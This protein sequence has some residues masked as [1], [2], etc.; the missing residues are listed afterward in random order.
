M[1][2][3]ATFVYKLASWACLVTMYTG[4]ILKASNH[5]LLVEKMSAFVDTG[6]FLIMLA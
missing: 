1:N 6:I 4:Y 5:P 2:I 3:S